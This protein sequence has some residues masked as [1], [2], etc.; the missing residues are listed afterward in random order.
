MVCPRPKKRYPT[1]GTAVSGNI[2]AAAR[3]PQPSCSLMERMLPGLAAANWTPGWLLRKS[4]Q[5]GPMPSFGPDRQKEKMLWVQGSFGGG[6][7]AHQTPRRLR[8]RKWRHCLCIS[9]VFSISAWCTA[10]A[11]GSAIV[12]CQG[13]RPAPRGPQQPH[14]WTGIRI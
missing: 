1:S 4:F 12:Q 10:G 11:W 3:I 8:K 7:S 2:V 13:T 6:F 14:D 9:I 5:I